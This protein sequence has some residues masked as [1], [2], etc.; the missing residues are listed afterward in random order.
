ML[1]GFSESEAV[2]LRKLWRDFLV[3]SYLNCNY[4]WCNPTKSDISDVEMYVFNFFQTTVE[5]ERIEIE[6]SYLN[7]RFFGIGG[8]KLVYFQVCNYT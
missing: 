3:W 8:K 1:S 2:M 7:R 5:T 4:I 6:S